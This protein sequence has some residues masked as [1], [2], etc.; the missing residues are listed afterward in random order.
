MYDGFNVHQYALVCPTKF[1]ITEIIYLW[2]LI[3]LYC[4][5]QKHDFFVV[6]LYRIIVI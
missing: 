5:H 2:V 3:K 6:I 1:A 4:A